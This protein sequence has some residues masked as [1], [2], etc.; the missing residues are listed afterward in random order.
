MVIY[1]HS[2][3]SSFEQC[4]LKFKFRYID[5]IKPEI[6]ETIESFL[7]HK[8]HETLKF[9]HEEVIKGV[10]IQLDD[11]LRHFIEIWNKD[12]NNEIK[13]VKQEYNAEHYFH[14][15]IKFLIDYFLKNSP[16]KD[17]TI[18]TEKRIIINLDSEGKY[19]LQG[20][21]DRLVY[22]KEN[23]IYEIHDYK[24]NGFLKSQEELDKDRQLALYAIGIRNNF[25]NVKEVRLIW[26]FLAFNKKIISKR[27]EQ[28]FEKLKQEII[29]LIDKIE[30]TT[31]FLPNQG[32][33]CEW[34]EFQNT[35]PLFNSQSSSPES[36]SSPVSP[37][38]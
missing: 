26:H 20:Y 34:C 37:E 22:N 3:L 30:S 4:P 8:V 28:E 27:T 19:K 29:E 24:T 1:S 14:Q 18:A 15:G 10:I 25:D 35:C 23:N 16:F 6:E 38:E 5:K 32:K 31:E 2:R 21:I 36:F 11:V 33:L 12:F 17:N 9:L 13:I 7:G